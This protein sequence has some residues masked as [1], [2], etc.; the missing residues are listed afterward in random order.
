MLV[1]N[2][3]ILKR[4]FLY[5]FFVFC[6]NILSLNLSYAAK[7]TVSPLTLN[8]PD[9]GPGFADIMVYNTGDS[10][11]YVQLDLYKIQDP[12]TKS[13]KKIKEDIKNPIEFGLVASPLKMVIPVNQSR[14]ARLLPLSRKLSQ[15]TV[16]KLEVIPV[17]GDLKLIGS[18]DNKINA[19]VNAGV[20][21][22]VGYGVRVALL[23]EHIH[24]EVSIV[25]DKNKNNDFIYNLKN[26]GNVDV[27]ISEAEICD[28]K[29][30]I[31]NP[32]DWIN[33]KSLKS[34][35]KRL[36]PGNIFLFSDDLFMQKYI[37]SEFKSKIIR[38]KGYFSNKIFYVGF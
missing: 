31:T 21:V 8:I 4:L 36:Y 10:K 3:I 12:G 23:P 37:K 11:A 34:Y 20:K 17:E 27:L 18:G 32:K 29:D 16:Y 6:I 24:Q 1:I 9:D 30:S 25:Q 19:G 2:K 5:F 26:T 33:C 15:E 7:I 38:F 28:K 35:S 14:K 13:E 22:T